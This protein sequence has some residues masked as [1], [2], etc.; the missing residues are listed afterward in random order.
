MQYQK[1]MEEYKNELVYSAKF[2]FEPV[3][4][5]LSFI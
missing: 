2:S 3:I 1:L 4:G 5:N